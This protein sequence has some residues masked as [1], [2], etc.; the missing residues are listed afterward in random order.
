M[1]TAQHLAR[2]KEHYEALYR[3]RGDHHFIGSGYEV[4]HENTVAR[5]A[6]GDSIVD[7]GCGSG[8]HSRLFASRGLEVTGVELSDTAVGLC[9]E[10]FAKAGLEGTFHCGDIR[11][12]PFADRTFDASF[13]SLVLHHFL[14][15]EQVLREAARVSKRYV[16]VFEPNAAN[17][18]SYLLLNVL[19]RFMRVNF[20]TPNQ[21]A[22]SPRRVAAI[23]AACGYQATNAPVYTSLSST[24][25]QSRLK[26]VLHGV[27]RLLPPH[28]RH[29]KFIQ[30]FERLEL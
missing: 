23:L 26:Q 16:F 3:G 20:L 27:Q 21:R 13:L 18:Q 6:A 9:R 24:A 22:V 5:L 2:E 8:Q 25:E 10:N 12:L 30:T 11:T 4:V 7:I 19:N 17:P 29:T 14:D 1:A 15:F 28:L